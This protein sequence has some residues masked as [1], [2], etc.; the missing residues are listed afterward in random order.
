M[1]RIL[2]IGA[3]LS[4]SYLIH[5]LLQ[6][7]A[8]ADVNVTVADTNEAL[9]AAKVNGHPKAQAVRLDASNGDARRALITDQDIV[10]SLLPPAMHVPVAKDCIELRKHLV[11]AS[12]VSD[13]MRAL[14]SEARKAGVLLLN[15]CGLDPGIDHLSAMKLIHE[16]QAKG[17]TI[18][19]FKSHCGGLVAPEFDNNPWKY[20]FTWNPR[21]VVLAGQATAKYLDHG[22]L[23][24][25]P[26]AQLFEQTEPVSCAGQS[27]ESYA[28]RDSLGYIIPY[29]IESAQTV[30]RGTLRREGYCEAWNMLVKLGL[31]DDTFTLPQSDSLTLREWVHAFVPGTDLNALEDRLATY[32]NISRNSAVY[33]KLEWLGLFSD[34]RITLQQATPAQILQHLLTNKWKLEEGELDMIVMKHELDYVLH[35]QNHTVQSELM[36][37][38][39]NKQ[40]TAMAKTVGLPLGIATRLILEGKVQETGVQIPLQPQWYEPMLQELATYGIQFH[41]FQVR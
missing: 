2:V 3:G 29:G 8:N 24:F 41:E 13:D 18:T 33:A 39:E 36:V 37:K 22:R 17:G 14:D 7:A 38:G 6:Y 16:I 27:F 31:T 11:T 9:A 21:N 26:P 10:I 5:Y 15:E 35:G 28:N 23:K 20:K 30:L 40:L 32:L 12:Y 1:Q 4:S 34:E 19:A 25:I